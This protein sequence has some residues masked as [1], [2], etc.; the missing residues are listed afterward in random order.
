MA[1]TID[2][3]TCIGCGACESACPLDAISVDDVAS[4]DED[5]CCECGA[6][7]SSCAVDAISL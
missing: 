6:C 2:T 7:I 5:V 4:V 3:D 1:I